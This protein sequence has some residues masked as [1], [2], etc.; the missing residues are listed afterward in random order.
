MTGR[1][2]PWQVK[3]TA[4]ATSDNR[5]YFQRRSDHSVIDLGAGLGRER[6]I[7]A[8][9]LEGDKGSPEAM[10]GRRVLV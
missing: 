9:P 8:E 1:E 6:G 4:F 2:C 3:G 5:Q 7:A 10:V